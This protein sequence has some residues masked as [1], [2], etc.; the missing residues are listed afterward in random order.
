MDYLHNS[1]RLRIPGG[2]WILVLVIYS[3]SIN[4]FLNNSNSPPWSNVIYTG[5]GYRPNHVVS[6]KFTVV[7]F[8]LSLYCVTSNHMVMASIIVIDLTIKGYF[9]F[10]CIL[11]ERIRSTYSLFHGVS[12]GSSKGN[13]PYFAI[14]RFVCWHVS[15]YVNSL[16]T[17]Y[18]KP[19]Q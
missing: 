10:L 5:H 18:Y 4:L 17:A 12:S 2:I 16:Q 6:T 9:P 15:Q 13:L 7:M 11:Y 19:V 1:I 8:S 3:C 14:D